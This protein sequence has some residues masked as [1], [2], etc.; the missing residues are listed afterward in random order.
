MSSIYLAV[1]LTLL[2][3]I[4]ANTSH[5]VGGDLVLVVLLGL[6]GYGSL[7]AAEFQRERY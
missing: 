1:V 3:L 4:A 7:I 6:A 2:M 5:G